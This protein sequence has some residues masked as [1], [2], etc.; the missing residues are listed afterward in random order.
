VLG[1][2]GT[3]VLG[4]AD[5]RRTPIL[6]DVWIDGL[7]RVTYIKDYEIDDLKEWLGGTLASASTNS[8]IGCASLNLFFFVCL[9]LT[10]FL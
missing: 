1:K 3:L 2:R 8:R 4:S 9:F 7:G 5:K 6:A 10:L